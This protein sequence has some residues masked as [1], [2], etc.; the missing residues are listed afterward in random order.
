MLG[1]RKKNVMRKKPPKR[2]PLGRQ[3]TSSRTGRQKTRSDFG[4]AKYFA[5]IDWGIFRIKC[6][7]TCFAILWFVLWTR[8]WHWQVVEGVHLA[9][10]A[11]RQH[12]TSVLV[13]GK[14][15]NI[16]D[17][18]GQVLARSVECYSVYARP[19]DIKDALT[20]ANTLATILG[21]EEQEIYNQIT[22]TSR[23]FVWLTRQIDDITAEALQI[24]T[25]NGDIT[26]IGLSKEYERVYPFKQMAG[27]LLGFVGVDEQGLEGIE[28]VFDRHLASVPTRQLVQRDA[29]GRRFYLSTEK[30]TDPSGKELVLTLDTQIQFFAE[31]SIAKTV[32]NFGAT[33]GGVLVIDIPTGDILAWAQYPFFNPNAYKNYKPSQYKNRLALDALEPGSTLKPF[34]IAAALEENVITPDMIFNCENG[35]WKTKDITIRDTSVH[36][37]LPVYKILR[38][39]SNIGM[40]KIGQRVGADVYYKYLS[41]LGFGKRTAVPVTDSTGILRPAKEWFE[42]D[43]LSASFGQ[44]M[45]STA[46]QMAQAYLTLLNDGVYKPLRLTLNDTLQE[47]VEHKRIF[48]A[49]VSRE[50][51]AMLRDVVEEDGSGHRA[52]INGI[53]VGGKTGTAQ[54]ADQSGRYGTGRMASFVGFAPTENPR[55]LTLVMVDEPTRNQYGGVVAA[56]VFQEITNLAMTYGGHL[57]DVVFAET[58]EETLLKRGVQLK[59]NARDYK[60]SLPPAPLFNTATLENESKQEQY[61]TLPGHLTKASSVVPNVIGKTVRNA[62]ELF[63]RGGIVPQIKGQGQRVI[64]Q[65]PS[66]GS[67]WSEEQNT[68]YILW[69]SER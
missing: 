26:G 15:G 16:V 47:T 4:L 24:A 52:R 30:E 69:L 55:Y 46:L 18:H 67:A 49:N 65:S 1:F 27:Q 12:L 62:V 39:S 25:K 54:K 56:P 53:T 36:G 57:P 61:H 14:R 45:S 37:D 13:T 58:A 22:N 10:Q 41:A 42:I 7:V 20:T 43:L 44:S 50:V 32:N 19:N 51:L 9:E 68:Q 28:R 34:L 3:S 17:R 21:I 11:E 63:A 31:E 64:R 66:P 35:R 40:A 60:A 38:Y 29:L 59:K 48:A 2:E 8:A 5:N 6:V 23:K 33:W